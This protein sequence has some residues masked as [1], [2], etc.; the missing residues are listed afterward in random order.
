MI[1]V[2]DSPGPGAQAAELVRSGMDSFDARLEIQQPRAP[3]DM[4]GPD[5]DEGGPYIV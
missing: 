3:W 4:D 1:G 2:I 5:F